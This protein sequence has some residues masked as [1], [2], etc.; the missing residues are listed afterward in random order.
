MITEQQKLACKAIVSIFETGKAAGNPAACAIL[1]DGAGISYGAHQ[2]TDA[3]DSL[4]AILVEYL[5]RDGAMQ[6]AAKEVLAV[7]QADVSTRYRS[8]SSATPGVVHAVELLR[9]M[10]A[11]PIMAEAQE[12]VFERLYWQPAQDQAEGM[13]LVEPLSWAICYDT[14]IHSGPGGIAKIRARFPELPPIRGG[15][16]R[17][18]AAAYV[19]ARRAWLASRGGIVAQTVYRMDAFSALIAA[20]NWALTTPFSVR[21][22]RVD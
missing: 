6:S 19:T 9:K 17:R 1:P 11:D 15:D 16:E 13:G 14:A 3:S 10:G 12:A 7:V 5:R 8:I 22:V 2:A 21:G 4:D 20:G 18:W